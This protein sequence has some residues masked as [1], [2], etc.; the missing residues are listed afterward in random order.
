MCFRNSP[1]IGV[2]G[3]IPGCLLN[4]EIEPVSGLSLVKRVCK[5]FQDRKVSISNMQRLIFLFVLYALSCN[6]GLQR[7]K[8]FISHCTIAVLY[9][10]QSAV[11]YFLNV[12]IFQTQK[13][14][15]DF[16]LLALSL[17]CVIEAIKPEETA[18][19]SQAHNCMVKPMFYFPE[20][21][22]V[23][24]KGKFNMSAHKRSLRAPSA[25]H[26]I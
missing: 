26:V 14:C 3:R 6:L 8:C 18:K 15:L 25:P 21:I 10:P 16:D 7:R 17:I 13:V 24:I 19:T 22:V 9:F 5:Y 1:F 12:V 20:E 23:K 4:R 11:F 2:T